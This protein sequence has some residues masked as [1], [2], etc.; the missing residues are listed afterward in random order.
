MGIGSAVIS[1]H[2]EIF[3][4]KPGGSEFQRATITTVQ[5]TN[6]LSPLRNHDFPHNR[7]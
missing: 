6:L 5:H 1:P 7:C 3:F 4:L 2:G